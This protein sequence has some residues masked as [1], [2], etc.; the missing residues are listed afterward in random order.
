MPVSA[1][2]LR[3]RQR[4]GPKKTNR[5]SVGV[6]RGVECAIRLHL[7]QVLYDALFPGLRRPLTRS[8]VRQEAAR[9]TAAPEGAGVPSINLHGHVGLTCSKVLCDS[10][11]GE[12]NARAR[13]AGGAGR[14]CTAR[15]RRSARNNP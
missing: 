6:E 9:A 7:R 15:A 2:N 8:L 14:R 5:F 1:C 10:D 4:S 13:R 11:V 3:N 12:R